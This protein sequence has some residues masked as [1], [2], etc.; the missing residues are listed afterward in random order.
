MYVRPKFDAKVDWHTGIV[1]TQHVP[2]VL[3]YHISMQR[4]DKNEILEFPSQVCL[5]LRI[6]VCFEEPFK[7]VQIVLVYVFEGLFGFRPQI[8]PSLFDRQ[9]DC[10]KYWI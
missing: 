2:Q 4:K 6:I 10:I 1:G 8:L 5:H 3:D 7:V 9:L